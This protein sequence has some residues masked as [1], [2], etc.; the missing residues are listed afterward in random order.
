MQGR[1]DCGTHYRSGDWKVVCDQCG[2]VRYA[3]QVRKQWNNL[4]TCVTTCFEERH[5]QEFV[6][7]VIDNQVPPFV[8]PEVRIGIPVDIYSL[9]VD[10]TEYTVDQLGDHFLDVNEVTPESL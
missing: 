7:G 6:R 5:P 4:Y 8:R 2:L 3:S 9:T 10:S 1:S